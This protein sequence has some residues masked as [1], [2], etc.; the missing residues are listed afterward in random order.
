MFCYF[1]HNVCYTYI[2]KGEF[3]IMK[4][5]KSIIA[6]LCCFL[7]LTG[8]TPKSKSAPLSI[9]KE[10]ELLEKNTKLFV[11]ND[12]QLLKEADEIVNKY[13]QSLEERL[14][15]LGGKNNFKIIVEVE[16][17]LRSSL[18]LTNLVLEGNFHYGDRPF[19]VDTI[20]GP[21]STGPK[22]TFYNE[23]KS[24]YSGTL[25]VEAWMITANFGVNFSTVHSIT[26]EFQFDAIPSGKK[27]TYK[28]FTN[29]NKYRFYVYNGSNYY[30][31]SHYWTP[32]GIVIKQSLN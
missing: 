31:I 1:Y 2:K 17:T 25:G 13:A 26:R 18:I 6:L 32:V 19:L 22:I 10:T 30:G 8:F 23:A 7:L 3:Y 11:I 4:R 20:Y 24:G 5:L 27:L 21:M 14:N 28:A 15:V 12:P 9:S 16:N 29:Y